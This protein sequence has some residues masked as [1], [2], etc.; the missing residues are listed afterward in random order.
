MHPPPPVCNPGITNSILQ[1][2]IYYRAFPGPCPKE[3]LYCLCLTFE[4]DGTCQHVYE[5]LTLYCSTC[6]C[7]CHASFLSHTQMYVFL[8]VCNRQGLGTLQRTLERINR[9]LESKTACVSLDKEC[10]EVL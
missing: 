7:L 10:I 5:L 8:P 4:Y 1:L 2:G 3:V 9:D 6:D